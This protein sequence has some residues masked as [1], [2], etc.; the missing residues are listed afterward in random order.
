[1][2]RILSVW[3]VRVKRL[4]EPVRKLSRVPDSVDSRRTGKGER[5]PPVRFQ[6]ILRKS[7]PD[8]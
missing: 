7:G 1:M 4:A 3:V 8:P 2:N 6:N 5:T